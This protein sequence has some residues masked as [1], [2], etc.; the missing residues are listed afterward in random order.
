MASGSAAS[1][2]AARRILAR[3][4][5]EPKV[6]GQQVADEL[7]ALVDA[8]DADLALA[9]A[10]TNPNRSAADKGKAVRQAMAG[11]LEAAVKVAAEVA[12]LRWS[13]DGDLADGLEELAFD[14]ALAAAERAK[15]LETIEAEL[16]EVDAA[17]RNHRDL[18]TALGDL[19]ASSEAK[20]KLAEA[21]FKG[22]VRP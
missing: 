2:S 21:V 18:R 11:H 14:A 19:V 3:A 22:A 15:L 17:L 1:L 20:A 9:R 13:K 16:F 10:L 8:L 4:V 7:F 5:A 12:G 6:D